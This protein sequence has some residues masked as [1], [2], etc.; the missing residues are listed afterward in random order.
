MFG[1]SPPVREQLRTLTDL[2]D[3]R[4]LQRRFLAD[5]MLR[6]TELLLQERVPTA[7]APV[8]PHASEAN[9][10]RLVSAEESGSMRVF[11]DPNST[12]VEA[13]LLSNGRYHV[14]VT[15]AG[16]PQT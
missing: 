3:P 4:Q 9:A 1:L 13:H 8:F 14:A 5:P 15:S 6:A 2:C 7:T 11:T 12:V 16:A 10:K